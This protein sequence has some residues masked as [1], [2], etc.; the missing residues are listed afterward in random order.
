MALGQAMQ[1][2]ILLPFLLLGLL[3]AGVSSFFLWESNRRVYHLVLAS[4]GKSG[5]YYAFSQAFAEVASRNHR[6]LS[7]EVIETNG[8]EENMARLRDGQAHIALV[9]SDTPVD[10]PVRAVALLFPEM[11]HLIARTEAQITTVADLANKRVALM[12]EGSGSYALFWPLIAHYGLTA[13]SITPL[14]MTADAA[15]AALLA[16]EV[17]ALF[18]VITLGNTA[19]R[20][21]LQS[22]EVALLPI[23]QVDALRLSLPYLN[24]HVVPKGTYNGG[25]PTPGADLPVVAVNALLVAHEDLPDSVVYALTSTL[26]EHRNELVARY[27]RAAM[28]RLDVSGKDLGLPLHPG[29]ETFYQ[30]DEPEFI[31]EYAEPIGLLLSVSVLAIS[32][33]W[34][35]RLWLAS[36]QKNRADSYNLEILALIDRIEA[37]TSLTELAEL[38]Q[39]LFAILK[40][41]V[42]DLDIDRINTESFESFTFPWEIA[43]NSIR[44]REILL[45]EAKSGI[46]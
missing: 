35:V 4:G 13:S 43:L 29:A 17:D 9:Q 31:V 12:P 37:A 10:P 32:S 18:R 20:D 7:I 28:I 24:A 40:L 41:V 33:L 26:Y 30:Q 15:H 45:R 42:N 16:G 19:V 14:P 1:G 2:R 6:H 44:H 8:S 25:T 34:Q 22:P 3:G 23:D 5:E 27:P 46:V 21:L 39:Q 11:F 38:R 36:R